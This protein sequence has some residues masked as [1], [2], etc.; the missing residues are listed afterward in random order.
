VARVGRVALGDSFR[1]LNLV[2]F[3][4][5]KSFLMGGGE[6]SR[7]V[8]TLVLSEEECTKIGGKEETVDDFKIS[9]IF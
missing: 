4:C 9:L 8:D 7:I 2:K 6:S 5:V 1:H 3:G